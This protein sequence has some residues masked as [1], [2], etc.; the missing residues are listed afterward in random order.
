MP[1][2]KQEEPIS[3]TYND[4]VVTF[5]NY[6]ISVW[7]YRLFCYLLRSETLVEYNLHNSFHFPC[8][9]KDVD[10]FCSKINIIENFFTSA[11]RPC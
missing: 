8:G 5:Y 7:K 3:Y 6:T 1:R 11:R 4:K 2:Y 9:N 10:L